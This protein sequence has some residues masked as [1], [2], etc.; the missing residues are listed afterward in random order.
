MAAL[1]RRSHQR[2]EHKS[3]PVVHGIS[4][5]STPLTAALA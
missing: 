1:I 3:Y 5:P 4:R 2:R